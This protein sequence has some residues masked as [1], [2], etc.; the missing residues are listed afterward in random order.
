VLQGLRRSRDT[1]L[2]PATS[3]DVAAGS[4]QATQRVSTGGTQ[5]GRV[6]DHQVLL[7]PR[8]PEVHPSVRGVQHVTEQC[9][10]ACWDCSMRRGVVGHTVAAM[11]GTPP[12]LRHG[13]SLPLSLP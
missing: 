11:L 8:I 2:L 3:A 9:S 6:A 4:V 7:S 12:L 13:G 5:L 1:G 10:A